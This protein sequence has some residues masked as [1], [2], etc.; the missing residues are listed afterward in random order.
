MPKIQE[1]AIHYQADGIVKL[2]LTW[3]DCDQ[4]LYSQFW[5]TLAESDGL[6][7]RHAAG[8]AGMQE[9]GFCHVGG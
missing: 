1:Y 7:D 8:K 3:L 2:D 4:L 6:K 9:P 5:I